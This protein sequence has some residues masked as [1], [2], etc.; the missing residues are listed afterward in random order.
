MMFKTYKPTGTVLAEQ[1]CQ[2]ETQPE[3]VTTY[4]MPDSTIVHRYWFQLKGGHPQCVSIKRGDWLVRDGDNETV[5]TDA[6]FRAKYKPVEEPSESAAERGM[7]DMGFER[8][9]TADGQV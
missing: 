3:W 4:I 2:G 9:E 8:K 1:F 7:E 6:E 5:M